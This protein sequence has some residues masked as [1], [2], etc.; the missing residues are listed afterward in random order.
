MDNIK[1]QTMFNKIPG[2]EVYRINLA[3]QIIDKE[4]QE[5]TLVVDEDIVEIELYGEVKRVGLTWLSLIAHYEVNLPKG[6]EHRL[7]DISFQDIQSK[8]I[9][10]HCSKI[11]YFK[12]PVKL[13]EDYRII[14]NYTDY[15]VSKDGRVLDIGKQR[16]ISVNLNDQYPTV[17]IYDPDRKKRRDVF[18]H[19]LV[20][21]AWRMH[22]NFEEKPYVNHK[23]GDK[24][25]YHY[26]NLEWCSV[27]ENNLHAF[28]EGLREDNIPCKVY[29]IIDKKE[30]VFSSISQANIFMGFDSLQVKNLK[31]RKRDRLINE[32][33][34]IK[35]LDDSSPW[36]YENRGLTEK[37]GRYSLFVTDEDGTITE[38]P[39]VRT[40]KKL[41]R[42]WN[43]SSIESLME[44]FKYLY[45]NKD[46]SYE[47]HYEVTSVEAYNVSNGIIVEAN[48]VRPIASM[49]GLDY[50]GVY[51]ALNKG[52]T[53]V[54]KGYAFRRKTNEDWDT[55][56]IQNKY[57]PM[58]ISATHIETKEQL[59]FKS[60]REAAKYFDVD[61]CVIKRHLKK[62]L[63]LK[64]YMLQNV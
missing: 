18:L 51:H 64:S 16:I 31:F 58:C 49:L 12:K 32:R 22:N 1:E 17:Y 53:Y 55:N 14:P 11:M 2:N 23:D 39:D 60:L 9:K 28:N 3:K 45:P 5:C 30:Y 63:I 27:S 38:Y 6:F 26:R 42:V 24:Q 19:R 15:A 33:Y 50:N 20:A 8:I 52:Q 10:I 57:E 47:D 61:R 54:Y 62:R 46:I 25:H 35:T 43:V 41:F 7:A 48:G 56:F 13:T 40:F 44:R 4:G 34:Q 37:A 36:F 21:L 29:D 59:S